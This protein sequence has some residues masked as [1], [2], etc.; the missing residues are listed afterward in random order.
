M[1]ERRRLFVGLMADEGM[2][3]A[4]EALRSS[5]A[6]PSGA[7]MV[8]RHNLHLTLN[9]LGDVEVV[10][11][12]SLVEALADVRVPEL[13]LTFDASGVWH[14]GVVVLLAEGNA[15]L[16][17]LWRATTS[18]VTAAGLQSDPQW[19]PHVTLARHAA[20]VQ[21]PAEI[22]PVIWAPR[23]M[24]LVW[25]RRDASG[26]EVVRSWPAV[27]GPAAPPDAPTER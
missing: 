22:E 8:P 1:N 16:D 11:E 24:S 13:Q 23:A 2:R 26:Y 27:T 4:L 15:A 9:F 7:R 5:W 21:A 3:D 17:A 19:T 20:A 25:S 12:V 10:D 6:W 18:A 14:D